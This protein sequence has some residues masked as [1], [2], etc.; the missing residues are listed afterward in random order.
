MVC[1]EEK[2]EEEEGGGGGG[3][4]GEERRE[5]VC[6]GGVSLLFQVCTEEERSGRGRTISGCMGMSLWSGKHF[7][8]H[9]PPPLYD[10]F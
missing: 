7:F 8:F 2:E 4:G 10:I 1:A 5:Q 9:P 3:G 6:L